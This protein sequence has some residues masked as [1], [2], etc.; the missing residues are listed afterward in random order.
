METHAGDAVTAMFYQPSPFMNRGQPSVPGNWDGLDATVGILTDLAVGAL[1]SGYIAVLYLNLIGASP[2]AA[3]LPYVVKAATAWC[4]GYGSDTNFWSE[5]DIGH[6]LCAWL[7][8]TMANDPIAAIRISE[9]RDDLLRCLD[10][11]IQSGVSQASEI[12]VRIS[13]MTINRKTA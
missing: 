6:R 8:T 2:R 3:L 9:V 5:R 11:L 1:T 7:D 4:S 13:A 10:I 12:E